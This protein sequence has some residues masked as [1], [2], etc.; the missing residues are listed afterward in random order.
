MKAS[1]VVGMLF[2]ALAAEAADLPAVTITSPENF[3]V[4]NVYPPNPL[5]PELPSELPVDVTVAFQVANWVFPAL[6]KGLLFLLDGPPA[7]A[8]GTNDGPAFVFQVP[9]GQHTLWVCLATKVQANDGMAWGPFDADPMAE[10]LQVAC[11]SVVVNVA[12]VGCHPTIWEPAQGAYVCD[13]AHPDA[14]CIDTNPCSV[15]NCQY[16]TSGG[17]NQYECRFGPASAACCQTVLDCLGAGQECDAATHLC[18]EPTGEP[19]PIDWEPEPVQPEPAPE[20]PPEPAEPQPEPVVEPS[21][22]V[23]EPAPDVPVH[24]D[25]DAGPLPDAKTDVAISDTHGATDATAEAAASGDTTSGSGSGGGSC[26]WPAAAP[27][28][29]ALLSVLLALG[30]TLRVRTRH[31]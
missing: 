2:A 3:T 28:T 15:D 26:A 27:S 8:V 18:V 24:A 10:D 30:V 23:A 22:E 31:R 29:G 13:P 17:V 21:P 14:C 4:F 12:L 16:V 5:T 11:D 6:N 20:A 19:H 1:I 7:V 9:L 25:T